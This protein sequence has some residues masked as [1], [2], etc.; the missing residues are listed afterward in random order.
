MSSGP[1]GPILTQDFSFVWTGCIDFLS[2]QVN[3]PLS[4]IFV[5]QSLT[6]LATK[7]DICLFMK[8]RCVT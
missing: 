4:V 2:F 1:Y 3:G 5:E 6:D 8:E 7:R